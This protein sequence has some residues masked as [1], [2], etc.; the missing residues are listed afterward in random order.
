M[1]VEDTECHHF[2]SVGNDTP[3]SFLLLIN[4]NAACISEILCN[5]YFYISMNN[6]S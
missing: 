4:S 2:A 1:V 6:F 5:M 3:S